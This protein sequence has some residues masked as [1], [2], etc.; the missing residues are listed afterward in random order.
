MKLRTEALPFSVEVVTSPGLINCI[1]AQR[2]VEYRSHYGE[3]ALSLK[4]PEPDDTHPDAL[5]VAAISTEDSSILGSF[6]L[7]RD[8][9]AEEKIAIIE[10]H[11][12]FTIS[13]KSA[14]VSRLFVS[15]TIGQVKVRNTL[16]KFLHRYCFSMQIQN[17][18]VA[19]KPPLDKIYQRLGFKPALESDQLIPNEWS[20]NHKTRIMYLDTVEVV[21]DWHRN[22]HDLYDFMATSFHPNIKI[23][24]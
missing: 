16:F 7:E 1:A 19:A 15:K 14:L 20:G 21:V 3:F 10:K 18:L 9:L 12:Q 8:S 11:G 17:I 22:R 23:N 2:S 24:R 5:L 6:R 13:G 4:T